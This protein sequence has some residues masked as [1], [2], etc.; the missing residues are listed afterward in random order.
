[1]PYQDPLSHLVPG[2]DTDVDAVIALELC[3]P[4]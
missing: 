1:M 3:S 4:F 2:E